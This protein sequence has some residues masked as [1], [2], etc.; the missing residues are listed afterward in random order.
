MENSDV[1]KFRE[2]TN[3][4]FAGGVRAILFEICGC[5]EKRA[6]RVLE[7]VRADIFKRKK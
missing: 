1:L 4:K 3:E 7:L 6:F 2:E 5:D